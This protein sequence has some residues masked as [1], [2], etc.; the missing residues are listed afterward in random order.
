[1]E[2]TITQRRENP[3]LGRTE[4]LFMILHEGSGTPQRVEIRKALAAAVGAQGGL[5]ILDWARSDFGRTAT[6]G[7]AKVYKEKDRAIEVETRPILVR[8]GLREAAKKA[9]AAPAPAAAPPPAK[10]EA[11]K[12]EAPKKES[13]APKA[14]PAKKEAPKP[15]A[16]KEEAPAKGE[17]KEAPSPKKEPGAKEK[18]PAGKKEGK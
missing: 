14:E 13:P 18:K 11:A 7:Y 9:E 2:V 16:K 12:P 3:L 8:N 4:V 15:E 6:R 17:K 10:K 1:M 5:V